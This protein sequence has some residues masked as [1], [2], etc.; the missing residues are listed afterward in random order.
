MKATMHNRLIRWAT[1][2]L[3]AS[4]VVG[5][6]SGA[7]SEAANRASAAA[8]NQTVAAPNAPASPSKNF[9]D[10]NVLD[11]NVI[12]DEIEKQDLPAIFQAMLD[13]KRVDHDPTKQMALQT[14][15]VGAFRTKRPSA[16]FMEQ[17]GAFL[18]N[19]SNLKSERDLVIGALGAA[20][21]KETVDLL[22]KIATTSPDPTL[23]KLAG[24]YSG[25]G[26]PGGAGEKLSPSLEKVWRESNDPKLL[27]S[28]AG[29]M[30]EIG[31]P[32]GIELLL[33]AALATDD[34][35]KT[36]KIAAQG[37]MKRIFLDNAV[38]PLAARLVG[39]PPT[40]ETVKLVAPI[41][42]RIGNDAAGQAVVKWLQNTRENVAPF[43]E[44]LIVQYSSGP[45]MSA[46]WTA[47]LKPAVKFRNEKNREAIRAALAAQRAGGAQGSVP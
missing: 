3:L 33:S 15:F 21:T 14:V 36:R 27:I 6:V 35:D 46:A 4:G 5:Q 42:V 31:T 39:Q 13:A 40:S 28:V 37:A 19:S 8:P 45:A 7:N 22:L 47:A 20:A 41:L 38:P 29:T 32:S 2:V 30:A 44:D 17:M 11:R 10:M 24:A 9:Y 12:L 1:V 23:R 18:A 16:E 26:L 34:K 25:A 43:I